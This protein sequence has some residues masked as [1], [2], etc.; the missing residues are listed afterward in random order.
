MT[1]D[2]FLTQH[3]AQEDRD[4]WLVTCPAHPDSHASLR[5]AVGRER[6]LLK[7]RAGCTTEDVLKAW[8]LSWSDLPAVDG[9]SVSRRV[10]PDVP[11]DPAAVA[12]LA[13]Q[14]DAWADDLAEGQDDTALTYLEARF[15]LTIEDAARLG[16]GYADD[17]GGGPRVV[18][19]FRDAEGVARGYQ[20]RALA[21]DAAVRWLGP[22]NPES[23]TWA[24][25]A[26]FR[27]GSGW[28]EVLVTEGPGDGLTG[29]GLGYDTAAIRGAGLASNPAVVAEVADFVGERCAVLAGDGD[30][31]GQRFNS[32]LAAALLARGTRVKLLP[33]PDGSDLTKWRETVGGERFAREVTRAVMQA[34]ELTSSTAALASRDEAECPLTDLGNARFVRAYII[35]RGSDVRYSPEGGFFLLR[36]G[37]W[38]LDKLDRV[39]EYAQDAAVV[40]AQI[41]A[42]LAREAG[43]DTALIAEAKRW[44]GWSRHSQS[45]RG[46]DS[47]IRELQALSGVAVDI[48][49]FDRHEHLLAARNGVVNLRTGALQPHDPALLLTKRVDFDYDPDARAPRWDRFLAEVFPNHP[50]LPEYVRRLVGYGVTGSTAEQCFAVL[51]GKGANGK[52]VFTDTLTEVF[53]DFTTTTPFSTFEERPAGGIPNDIAAL[54]GARLVMASEGEAG[55]AMAEAVLKRVTGR[56]LIAARFM[57]R[58]FFEFRPSFL[59]MLATNNKPNFRGQDEG[60]WRRVKLIPWERYFAPD[61]R[62]HKLGDALLAERAGILAWAVRGAVEWYAGGLQDPDTV[63]GATKEYRETSDALAGFLGRDGRP[64]SLTGAGYVA[65]YSDDDWVLGA[66]LWRD[67]LEWADD[68]NLPA[69]E[70]WTQRMFFTELEGRGLA[71]RKRNTG[72]V[73]MGVR[74]VRVT[75]RE[76][77]HSEPERAEPEQLA[78]YSGVTLKAGPSLGSIL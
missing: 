33:V 32:T 12:A 68:Q 45:T 57:R 21:N 4:G 16:L 70:K 18:V 69:R 52:S 3:N 34:R 7:C 67:Y 9:V 20:A 41:A 78:P 50:D 63:R 25:V 39:R 75:D 19:P 44:S 11:A 27:G 14:L 31:A 8:G 64:D 53:R 1:L 62:D 43:T 38:H 71:K 60:L 37:V 23:G 51:W 13:V 24:K 42:T 29:C 56:D 72:I 28:D 58:E 77:N 2:D 17:L 30:E 47:A 66:T 48:L 10:A 46:I 74:K 15:G 5:V 73:F 65:T 76:P 6:L 36:E 59:L 55:K 22:A 54:K 49:D 35:G 40:T 61:E 26:I